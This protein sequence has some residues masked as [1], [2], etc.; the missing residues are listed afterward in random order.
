[1]C[2][3]S[4]CLMCANC[5]Q[6]PKY[7]GTQHTRAHTLHAHEGTIG[8]L[9]NEIPRFRQ[10]SGPAGERKAPPWMLWD[11]SGARGHN[12]QTNERS[13]TWTHINVKNNQLT[14]RWRPG[15]FYGNFQLGFRSSW[16][17]RGCNLLSLQKKKRLTNFLEECMLPP[18]GGWHCA[19]GRMDVSI[20]A[21]MS[22]YDWI[23]GWVREWM[24]AWPYINSLLYIL[25]DHR[26]K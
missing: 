15:F 7:A 14:W 22:L 10:R 23:D 3:T 19:D 16:Q 25:G 21:C 5:P 4:D 18:Q 12:W 24:N 1:M 11:G 9:R 2:T 17:W 26:N 13:E 6:I 20:Y 8:H